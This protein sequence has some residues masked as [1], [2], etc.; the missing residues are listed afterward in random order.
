MNISFNIIQG[1]LSSDFLHYDI[2]I[3]RTKYYI[4]FKKENDRFIYIIDLL[5]NELLFYLF[6]EIIQDGSAKILDL[7]PKRLSLL[8]K[9]MREH[10]TFLFLSIS[11][12]STPCSGNPVEITYILRVS[13][14]SVNLRSTFLLHLVFDL[15]ILYLLRNSAEVQVCLGKYLFR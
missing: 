5:D 2:L 14:I 11:C 7:E 10:A 13:F 15:W 3:K 8:P 4:C 6:Q 9:Q 1:I 12:L